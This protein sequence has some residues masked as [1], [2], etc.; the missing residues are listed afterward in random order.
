MGWVV[1][2]YVCVSMGGGWVGVGAVIYS[3]TC[4]QVCLVAIHMYYLCKLLND[5]PIRCNVKVLVQFNNL[6]S[7]DLDNG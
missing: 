5:L 4:I 1:V 7:S 6:V 2:V 3:Y